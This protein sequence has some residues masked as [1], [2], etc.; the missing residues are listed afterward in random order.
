M[1]IN[2]K[3]SCLI[4][5]VFSLMLLVN[6]LHAE[7]P[8]NKK[9][10]KKEGIEITK[11][12]IDKPEIQEITSIPQT[13]PVE[14]GSLLSG[15]LSFLKILLIG[16]IALGAGYLFYGIYLRYERNRER[17]FKII[18]D[19]LIRME[20][21][22]FSMR[23]SLHDKGIGYT[24]PSQEISKFYKKIEAIEKQLNIYSNEHKKILDESRQQQRL[25]SLLQELFRKETSVHE[26]ILQEIN[27]VQ[28]GSI[29]YEEPEIK[30]DEPEIRKEE[31]ERPI[32]QTKNY[33]PNKI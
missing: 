33:S 10:D 7:L 17:Q 5:A 16:V 12:E 32:L 27:K 28:S 29:S 15:I 8:S 9:S 23:E 25:Y 18:E 19:F 11:P 14:E 4:W 3:S 31:P 6:Q 1:K 24:Y 26:G 30:R 2:F 20:R 22:Q 21:M 13:L